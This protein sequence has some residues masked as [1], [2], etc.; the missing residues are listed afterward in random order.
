MGKLRHRK[1]F[2]FEP[3]RPK[4]LSF[5]ASLFPL[6]E[7]ER[8]RERQTDRQTDRQRKPCRLVRVSGREFG[9]DWAPGQKWVCQERGCG[10]GWKSR[11]VPH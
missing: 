1:E 4:Q 5:P 3:L 8:E 11:N 2:S 10:L 7:R 6:R 9:K